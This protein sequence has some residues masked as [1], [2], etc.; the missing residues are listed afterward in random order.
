MPLACA[1]ALRVKTFGSLLAK[2]AT[3]LT[4][5]ITSAVFHPSFSFM[6]C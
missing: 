1:N 5:S 3:E 2:C 4:S 6:A